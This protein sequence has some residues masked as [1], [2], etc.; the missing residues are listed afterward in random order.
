MHLLCRDS[1]SCDASEN[2]KSK[3]GTHS[4]G[5]LGTVP[6]SFKKSFLGHSLFA[7]SKKTPASLL[8][9]FAILRLSDPHQAPRALLHLFRQLAEVLRCHAHILN[10]FADVLVIRAHQGLNGLHG[11][12]GLIKRGL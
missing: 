8:R 6:A 7:V 3:G 10:R 5:T 4:R 1:D 2:G 9:D 11:A 12:C